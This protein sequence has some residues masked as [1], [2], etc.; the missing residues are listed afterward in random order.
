MIET[1]TSRL[2][3]VAGTLEIAEA[4][5]EGRAP[6]E[7][8]LEAEV[9]PDWP[10]ESIRDALS[11][12]LDLYREHPEWLG[13]LGWYAISTEA[14]PV[15]CGSVGFKGPPNEAGMVEIGYSLLPDYQGHGLASEMVR[16]LIDWALRQSKVR[17]IE[18]ETAPDNHPSIRVLERNRFER[19]GE[20]SER[21]FVRFRRSFSTQR[22]EGNQDAKK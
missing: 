4:E 2:R 22:H 9:P 6:L 21:G 3:L 1:R 18:A 19:V 12:F 14:A 10:P 15:L 5:I 13:W 7:M 8:L 11:F 20:G 16:G 17:V